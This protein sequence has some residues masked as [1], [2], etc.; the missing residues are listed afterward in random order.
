[1]YGRGPAGLLMWARPFDEWVHRQDIRRALGLPDED[2]DLEN[3]AEFVLECVVTNTL[4]KLE[5]ES[6]RVTLA[7]ERASLP[8]WGYDLG[9][10]TGGPQ[11]SR[12]AQ[13]VIHV[14]AG[15]F[16]MAAAG[17]ERFADLEAQGTL[18]LEGDEDLARRFLAKVRIV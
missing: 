14:P 4:P 8:D 15:A 2:V 17:R 6:G 3:V 16:V 12:E 1:M 9:D 7:L 10:R 11:L 18:K 13:A 5:G